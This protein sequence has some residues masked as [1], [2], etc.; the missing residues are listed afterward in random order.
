[1][2]QRRAVLADQQTEQILQR[3]LV[4]QG[5]FFAPLYK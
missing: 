4:C 5:H 2:R 3:E 1:M